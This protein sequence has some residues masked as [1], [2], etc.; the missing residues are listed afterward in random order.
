M[1]YI[2]DFVNNMEP[3]KRDGVTVYKVNHLTHNRIEVGYIAQN[4][5]LMFRSPKSEVTSNTPTTY[6][7]NFEIPGTDN[8]AQFYTSIKSD[9]REVLVKEGNNTWSIGYFDNG[10][11]VLWSQYE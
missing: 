5:R 10:K 8:E 2:L 9:N 3:I 4:G 7:C 6:R 11:L 1:T